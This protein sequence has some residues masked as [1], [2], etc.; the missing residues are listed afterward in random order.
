MCAP[1]GGSTACCCWVRPAQ[2]PAAVCGRLRR[3]ARAAQLH[4]CAG[5]AAAWRAATTLYPES[6][7]ACRD[8]NAMLPRAAPGG[9]RRTRP[10]A[11]PALGA[12]ASV[13]VECGVGN[14]QSTAHVA[15][16]AAL[17]PCAAWR[18]SGRC[19]PR[20]GCASTR[21]PRSPA[22][23]TST[24]TAPPTRTLSSRRTTS[25]AAPGCGCV[26]QRSC[27]RAIFGAVS[28]ACCACSS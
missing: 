5:L 6:A 15:V 11:L 22:S 7:P 16:T 21:R 28:A 24:T 1:S 9:C 20:S 26:A 25:R 8:T 3:A 14:V 23:T 27:G 18:C 2:A 4:A 17:R 10:P 12:R 13:Q 19:M